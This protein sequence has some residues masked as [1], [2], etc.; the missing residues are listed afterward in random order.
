MAR[1]IKVGFLTR[2]AP[3]ADY[4]VTS[5]TEKVGTEREEGKRSGEWKQEIGKKII[6]LL[7]GLLLI[8]SE[9]RSTEGIPCLLYQEQPR[10][11][12]KL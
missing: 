9:E 3:S 8:Y 7:W 11:K 5:H 10:K 12:I 1:K 4:W 2:L 6:F